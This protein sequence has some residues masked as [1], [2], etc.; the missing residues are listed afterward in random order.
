MERVL[1]DVL[2]M[3]VLR[4]VLEVRA[5]DRLLPASILDFKPRLGNHY[6]ETHKNGPRAAAI[7]DFRG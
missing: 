3:G 1:G 5:K 4:D 6:R 7:L 2:G